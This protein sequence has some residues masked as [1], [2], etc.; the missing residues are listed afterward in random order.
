MRLWQAKGMKWRKWADGIDQVHRC[1]AGTFRRQ[2]P[3][4]GRVLDYLLGLLSPVER[5][6]GWQ[7]A[8]QAGD[9]TPDGV[10]RLLCTTGGM[11]IWFATIRRDTWLSIWPALVPPLL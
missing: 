6:N 11:P 2:E 7:M 8:E 1:I 3:R 9:T 4:Q 10:Q 5:K